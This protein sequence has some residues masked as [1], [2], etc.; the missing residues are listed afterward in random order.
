MTGRLSATLLRRP[1]L[2][3]FAAGGLASLAMPPAGVFPVLWIAFPILLH[4]VGHAPGAWPAFR[5]GWW[6]GFGFFVFGLYWIAF[7]LTV[8]LAR[9]FWLIPFAM[10]GLPAV[11]GLFTGAVTALWRLT[12]RSGVAGVLVFALLWG[13]GEWLRGH[14]LTGFPWNLMAY[15]WD[16][17]LPVAQLAAPI[18][19]YGL[20]TLTVAAA[21]MPAAFIV[22]RGGETARWKPALATAAGIAVLAGGAVWGAM[23]LAANPAGPEANHPG[24]T[25]RLVQPGIDQHEKWDSANWPAHFNLHI[26]LSRADADGVT[27]VIWPE[28]AA[29]FFL[30]REPQ[31]RQRI[32]RTV[33]RGAAAIVGAPRIEERP[34]AEPRYYNSAQIVA[35]DGTILD[36]YDKAHLVPFG[37]YVPFARWLPFAKVVAGAVD[38]SPG[39]GRRTLLAPGLPPFSPLICYEVIF[40]GRA[41]G[42]PLAGAGETAGAPLPPMWIMNITNDAWYG[43]TAGPYQHFAIARLRA[44]EEGLPLVRV[45]TNG[46][47]GLVDP[48]GRVLYALPLGASGWLDVPLPKPLEKKHQV[49]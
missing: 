19:A 9:L 25:L 5:R 26:E 11:L 28:T 42:P 22:G 27:H 44:I 7:A 41:V 2:T 38:Y 6:F 49:R 10:A 37:E 39:P 4:G 40:P 30:D 46:I 1:W 32:G 36:S 34:G 12:G 48:L 29:T 3:A 45:A 8:D 20:S 35:S 43:K 18:G 15:A 23:R 14:L 24:I 21:A 47:S 13:A 31:I 17:A 33:P 16:R